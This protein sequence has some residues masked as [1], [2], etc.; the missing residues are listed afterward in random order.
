MAALL[1][2]ARPFRNAGG[3][4]TGVRLSARRESGWPEFRKV[5]TGKSRGEN[6]LC[7]AKIVL[8][9][10]HVKHSGPIY[11][12]DLDRLEGNFPFPSYAILWYDFDQNADSNPL[13]C[14]EV[15]QND[16]R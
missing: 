8:V 13:I 5:K 4:E 16:V 6:A 3:G 1:A 10:F 2:N 11:V 15:F 12:L 7:G 14:Q 9:M